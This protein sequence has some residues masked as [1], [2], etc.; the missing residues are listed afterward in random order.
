MGPI[1]PAGLT[2]EA[3]PAGARGDIGPPGER[4]DIGP[5]G[6]KGEAGE[7][8]PEG[9]PGKLPVVKA[10]RDGEVH[11][12]GDVVTHAGTTWQALKDTGRSPGTRDWIALA[13]GIDPCG[14]FDPEAAYRRLSLVA[15]NGGSFIAIKDDPGPCP[16]DGW[17]LLVSQGKSGKQGPPGERGPQGERGMK[18]EPGKP[19]TA[20]MR[21]DVLTLTNGDGSTVE[22]DLGAG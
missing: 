9:R 17:L 8:G 18:G 20:T 22:L 2:G 21:G 11:Y 6:E 1:G 12:E 3:G 7:R 16:G 15:L 5:R 10:W 14:R 19:A 13:S 4:G